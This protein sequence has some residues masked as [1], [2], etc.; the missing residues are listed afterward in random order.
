[1]DL[2]TKLAVLDRIYKIYDDFAGSLDVACKK[3][4]AQCC[5]RNVTM[6]TLE[7]YKIVDY[8]VSNGKSGLFAKLKTESCKKRFQPKITTNKLADLCIQGKELPSEESDYLWGSC[9]LLIDDQCPL[10]PVRPFGCRC[11]VSKQSCG[12][13]G[14]AD[15]DSF[16]ITVNNL[17]L[18][19]IEHIDSLGFF[20]NLTDVLLFMESEKNRQ[21]Y[22][23]NTLKDTNA[24]LIS[25][26][27]IKV[28]LIP[29]EHR[30]KIKPILKAIQ[31]I[32]LAQK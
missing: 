9:P 22:R 20:G 16:V 26:L 23:L 2:N 10:Y 5:T 24:G 3:Y 14:Y 7:G 31:S 29:P 12:E 25:N 1:M 8:M 11:F 28:L 30:L 15:V 18:Q 17:F 27:P 13:K 4:C 32:G 6:T 19:T 21:C